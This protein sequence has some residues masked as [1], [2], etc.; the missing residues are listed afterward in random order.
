MDKL[1][2][3]NINSGSRKAYRVGNFKFINIMAELKVTKSTSVVSLKRQFKKDFDC[4]LVIYYGN[5]RIAEDAKKINEIAKAGFKG[6]NLTLGARSRV[7]NVED[8]FQDSFGIKVQI[9]NADGTKLAKNEM[10][11]TQAGKM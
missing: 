2:E 10:T 4:T 7:G 5:N 3:K 9:K 11:L 6:G 8:Y 1:Q